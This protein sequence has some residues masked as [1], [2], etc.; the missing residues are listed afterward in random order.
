MDH[1]SPR[2]TGVELGAA[3][4]D[5]RRT[6]RESRARRFDGRPYSRAELGELRSALTYV[7]SELGSAGIEA[8]RTQRVQGLIDEL[9]E[10]GLSER[11]L[12]AIVD[13]L[14]TIFA[15]AVGRGLLT[16]DPPAAPTDPMLDR[17][18]NVEKES[19]GA[20]A[21]GPAA[22]EVESEF[23]PVDDFLVLAQRARGLARR[24]GAIHEGMR[25][26]ERATSTHGAD[27]PLGPP[28]GPTLD[29][30]IDVEKESNGAA[31]DGRAAAEVESEFFPLDGSRTAAIQE[32]EGMRDDERPTPTH[33]VLALASRTA[34]LI[35]WFTVIA[36]ALVGAALVVEFV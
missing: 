21:D 8:L 24:T 36:F 7:D 22:S 14:R 35:V 9:R 29:Q 6:A 34:T 19:N 17:V 18:M 20:A 2:T 16:A 3:V 4:A 12:G 33:A 5:F 1:A 25:D 11:R 28:T 26:E 13:A 15:F 31:A 27:G 30:V 10:A 23:F 32:P